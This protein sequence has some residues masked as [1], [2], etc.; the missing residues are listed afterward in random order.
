MENVN[1]GEEAH[2]MGPDEARRQPLTADDFLSRL[3]D[4]ATLRGLELSDATLDGV[5]VRGLA[6]DDCRFVDVIVSGGVWEAVACTACA[7]V[8]CR[9]VEANLASAAFTR[10]DFFDAESAQG[11]SF[12]GAS[13]RFASFKDC[14]LDSS[15]FDDVDAYGVTIR[16]SRGIGANFASTAF[17]AS[18]TLTGNVLRY[19]DLRNANLA[20]CDLT[21]N[22]FEWANLERA[23][24]EGA[25]LRDATLNQAALRGANLRGADLRNANLGGLDVRQVDLRGAIIFETQMRQLLEA[26]ELTILS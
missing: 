11:C 19:A 15:L 25:T 26:L 6:L 12:I 23:T 1:D 7:F 17:D 22:D 8:R 13:L 10:C 20:R 3:E 9:F 16:D 21:K 18:A 14:T 5:D 24:L 4:G 2:G